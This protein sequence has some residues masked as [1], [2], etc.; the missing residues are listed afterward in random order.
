MKNSVL[1]NAVNPL[2]SLASAEVYAIPMLLLIG[3]RGEIHEDDY[4][5]KDEPQHIR[6]GQIT[7]KQL[8]IIDIPRFFKFFENFFLNFFEKIF[9]NFFEK[10]FLI[11]S[12]KFF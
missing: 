3:W 2:V 9:F 12:K 4:Q 7:L 10:N 8:E 6:Q 5:I 1:G 11:F